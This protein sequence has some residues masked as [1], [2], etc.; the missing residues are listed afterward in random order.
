L[1]ESDKKKEWEDVETSCLTKGSYYDLY[2]GSIYNVHYKYAE[3]QRIALVCSIFGPGIPLI[4]PI[5]LLNF[6]VLYFIETYKLVYCYRKPPN[7]PTELSKQLFRQL[8]YYCPFFYAG[9][10]FWM[11]SNRQIYGKNKISKEE[12]PF[13]PTYDTVVVPKSYHSDTIFKNHLIL[14]SFSH[15]S[16]GT[17][18]FALPFISLLIYLVLDQECFK[19]KP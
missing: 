15:F 4:F 2:A 14:D 18:F 12:D 10:G 6:T 11:F 3:I 1:D 16:P 9:F 5:G 19:E 8:V 7:L 13:H 17:L